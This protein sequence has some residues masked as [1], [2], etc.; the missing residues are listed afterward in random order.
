MDFRYVQSYHMRPRL[1]YYG[2]DKKKYS[3]EADKQLTIGIE[4]E[5]TDSYDE[6]PLLRD[7]WKL[8]DYDVDEGRYEIYYNRDCS[9]GNNGIELIT[10]PHT[11]PAFK[12]MKWKK[13]LNKITKHGYTSHENGKC[14]LHLHISRLFFGDD[15]QQERAI[16]K[17]LM[18][19]DAYY[20]EIVKI[21]RR[22]AYEAQHWARK[23]FA[24]TD[25]CDLGNKY[26]IYQYK[27]INKHESEHN[28]RYKIINLT[29]ANTI[30]FR[31]MR[32]TLKYETFMACLEFIYRLCLNVKHIRYNDM[33]N[34]KKW[35]RGL[36]Q[37]TK[38]Y[39]RS[40]NAFI[41]YLD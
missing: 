32:G 17:L 2:V 23:Q 29:N 35:L 11:W 25:K 8:Y 9:I 21:S 30:E 31:I 28:E 19:C 26:A 27:S 3:N 33:M 6:M 1:Y 36:S 13:I 40:K 24:S 37:N 15:F 34:V 7:L 20:D 12:K 4:L 14:G 10:Q 16:N 5:F 38:E 39:L 18:F 41:E 22:S